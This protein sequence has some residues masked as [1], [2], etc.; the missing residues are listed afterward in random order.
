ME[1]TSRLFFLV[2]KHQ[3]TLPNDSAIAI[4]TD[5]LRV[6]EDR[7]VFSLSLAVAGLA[8]ATD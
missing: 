7:T 6:D 1:P 8:R 5:G 3:Q 2:L 4:T